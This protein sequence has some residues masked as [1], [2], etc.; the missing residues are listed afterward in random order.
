MFSTF[1]PCAELSFVSARHNRLIRPIFFLSNNF[2]FFFSL[3]L[4]H[5]DPDELYNVA[6]AYPDVVESMDA[7][8]RSEIPYEQVDRQVKAQDAQLYKR[9]FAD[10]YSEK[11]LRNKFE[12]AV[13]LTIPKIRQPQSK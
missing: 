10:M 8:L 11:Q 2:F 12:S 6:S 5:L 3:S 4:A 7:L 13:R 9:F 1:D